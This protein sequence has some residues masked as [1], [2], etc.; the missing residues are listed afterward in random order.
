M[1]IIARNRAALV[2]ALTFRGFFMV[3]DLPRRIRIEE[4][5]GMLIARVS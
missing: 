2:E 3:V 4:R 5:R 1:T